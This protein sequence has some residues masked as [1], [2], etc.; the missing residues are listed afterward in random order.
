[1]I[2]SRYLSQVL[3]FEVYSAFHSC[4]QALQE[5]TC[6]TMKNRPLMHTPYLHIIMGYTIQSGTLFRKIIE[7]R[8]KDFTM[9]YRANNNLTAC[10]K[11]TIRT[12]FHPQNSQLSE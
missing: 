12:S 4:I 9:K 1:M 10:G 11:A 6:H 8:L 5:R 2:S 3:P 7:N